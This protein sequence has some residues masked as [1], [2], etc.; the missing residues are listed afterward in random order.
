MRDGA[1]WAHL[2]NLILRGSGGVKLRMTNQGGSSQL[3]FYENQSK[4]KTL[5]VQ[6]VTITGEC[7]TLLN[8]PSN[9]LQPSG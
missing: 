2:A 3:D 9:I 7:L 4:K 8:C 1:G 6:R 5:A